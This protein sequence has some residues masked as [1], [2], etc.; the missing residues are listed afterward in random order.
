MMFSPVARLYVRI[1]VL[2]AG[3]AVAAA[4]LGFSLWGGWGAA[5]GAV[6]AGLYVGGV[7]VF[8]RRRTA[9][10]LLAAR[11]QGEE[12]GLADA[13]VAGIAVYEAAVFPLTP[14]G[15]SEAEQKTRRTVA[16]QLAAHEA[17]PTVVRVAAA[18]AL[19]AIDAGRDRDQARAAVAALALTAYDCRAPR[20]AWRVRPPGGAEHDPLTGP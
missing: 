17:L 15:V 20:A 18:A 13:V 16:Y 4:C 5:V 9:A 19:E 12:A 10:S 14:G 8:H 6:L 11:A 1:A 2:G 3:M 7:M